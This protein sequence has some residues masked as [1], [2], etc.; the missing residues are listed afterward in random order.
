MKIQIKHKLIFTFILIAI[1][2]LMIFGLYSRFVM[3]KTIEDGV[4][5]SF[6][7]M[8]NN[9][10]ENINGILS[11]AILDADI[12]SKN[13]IMQDLISE[14]LDGRIENLIK[15][16]ANNNAYYKYIFVVDS[17]G[18]IVSTTDTSLKNKIFNV[19]VNG[20]DF[21]EIPLIE[22]GSFIIQKNIMASFDSSMQLGKLFIIID[23]DK[24]ENYI[25]K[26]NHGQLGQ[27]EKFAIAI[28]N[29]DRKRIL[30][31][32]KYENFNRISWEDIKAT[33]SNKMDFEKKRFVFFKGDN[34]DAVMSLTCLILERYNESYKNLI[35]LNRVNWIAYLV[36]VVV[37]LIVSIFFSRSITKHLVRI[38]AI[39]KDIAQGDA[40]L[41]K[42][43]EVT[44]KDEIGELAF[45]FNSFIVKLRE[46]IVNVKGNAA[47][48]A[49]NSEN[50]SVVSV[51]LNQESEKEKVEVEKITKDADLI[52]NTGDEIEGKV[53]IQVNSVQ[54]TSDFMRE[55]RK[56]TKGLKEQ[57][58]RLTYIVDKTSVELEK[59]SSSMSE[60][61]QN[62]DKIKDLVSNNQQ[63]TMAGKNKIKINQKSIEEVLQN[64]INFKSL[65]T[66]MA[67]SA[68]R[69]NV[70][71]EI[72]D[73]I[74]EQ[75]NLL[76][77]NAAIEAARAGEAG[78][79]FSVVADEIRKL[80]E[81][82]S[83]S[84]KEITDRIEEI[85]ERVNT[86][87]REIDNSLNLADKTNKITSE[88][89][90]VF[91]EINKGV[92]IIASSIN[93]VDVLINNQDASNKEVVRS[94]A[95]VSDI[96]NEVNQGAMKQERSI[97][98]IENAIFKLSE[99]TEDIK[100]EIQKQG[101]A[102]K[103][104]STQAANIKY[105]VDTSTDEVNHLSDVANLLKDGAL[106]LL[107]ILSRF[108]T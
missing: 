61:T 90:T 60:I 68:E 59:M 80:A 53:K 31:P 73:D 103:N 45:Y 89:V 81:R 36:V 76:A 65:V 19:D 12:Q 70:V 21:Q 32:F 63:V 98:Q 29:K 58:G 47:S 83:K 4:K 5:E 37:V 38:L 101:I 18:K 46:I 27:G 78:R 52:K 57:A 54:N 34:S 99:L 66:E 48:V 56:E 43:L 79:G 14:D 41:T 92:E 87:T 10:L 100:N 75:T 25:Y 40:D 17:G 35:N 62:S 1:V 9:I 11:R 96:T 74:S 107:D 88:S 7:T 16:I 69:I 39:M 102:N 64:I 13:E 6:Q 94:I 30:I 67:K 55:I 85:T 71:I 108:K 20:L 3:K 95:D 44:T 84:T 49:E 106:S 93:T 2:P 26:F 15:I 104:I 105:A 22:K 82:T 97:K 33:Y 77:L 72:I 28:Y 50:I 51:N 42:R 8:G 24:L 91:D 86:A 23:I